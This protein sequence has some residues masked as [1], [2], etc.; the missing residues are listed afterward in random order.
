MDLRQALGELARAT[1]APFQPERG[2]PGVFVLDALESPGLWFDSLWIAGL[3]AAAW[4]QPTAVDPWLP[5]EIQR[6]L[7]MPGVTAEDRVA[8]A[9]QVFEQWQRSCALLVFSWP[10]SENDTAVDASVVLPDCAAL[11]AP[12][13][14]PRREELLFAARRLEVHAADPAPARVPGPAAGGARLLEL[15][16]RCPFRAFAELRLAAAL[17]EEPAPGPDPCGGAVSASRTGYFW[18]ETGS[19]RTAGSLPI[20]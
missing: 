16:A 12:A 11:P 4:P 3:T 5:I 18:L 10:C 14:L 9:R 8:E 13:V 15:Q 17:L 6:Q 1:T 19:A 2:E 20:T 7:A